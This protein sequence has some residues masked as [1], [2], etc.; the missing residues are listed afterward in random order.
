MDRIKI[1][2]LYLKR[3]QTIKRGRRTINSQIP[4][5][6]TNTNK[7]CKSTIYTLFKTHSVDLSY[8][9]FVYVH[10]IYFFIF[11]DDIYKWPLSLK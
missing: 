6:S 2:V 3:V 5:Y 9:S 1:G 8:L 10:Y 11:L 7:L 4:Y